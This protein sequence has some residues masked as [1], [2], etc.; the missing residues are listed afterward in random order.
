MNRKQFLSLTASAA[1]LLAAPLAVVQA[2]APGS[3]SQL[4]GRA[5]TDVPEGKIEVVEFFWYG[6][7]HCFSFEPV[8]E[9]WH[10]KL[11]E[12]VVLRRVHVPFFSQPHQQMFYALQAI[13]REDAKTRDV[14]FRAIQQERK[15]LASIDEMVSVLAAAEVDGKAFRAAYNSFGVKTQMQRANKVVSAY[16]IDGVPALGVNGKYLTSPSVAG[17][18]QAVLQVLDQLL[19]RERKPAGG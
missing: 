17:S 5:P 6:C 12:D 18:N 4:H 16:G 19:S 3:Y 11:P 10:S 8:I 1:L 13:G 15:K 14:L 7:P 9:G 2:Q